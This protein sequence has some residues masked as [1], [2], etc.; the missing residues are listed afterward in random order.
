MRKSHS[1]QSRSNLLSIPHSPATSFFSRATRTMLIVKARWQLLGIISLYCLAACV[2]FL[3]TNYGFFLSYPQILF[4]ALSL[5]LVISYN[6]IFSLFY[7]KL[8]HL[9]WIDYLHIILDLL[10]ITGLIHFSGGSSSWFWPVYLIITIE[11]A[12]LLENGRCVM[13]I[14]FLGSLFYGALLIGEHTKLLTPV[15]MPASISTCDQSLPCVILMWSWVCFLNATVALVC[16]FFMKI[17]HKQAK[18]AGAREARLSSFL[19]HAH[20]L[21]FSFTP[22]GHIVYANKAWQDHLGYNPTTEHIHINQVMDNEQLLACQSKFTKI[23]H[24]EGIEPC[25]VTLLSSRGQTIA[26]E[27]SITCGQPILE[28]ETLL[29][30]MCRN[31]T[32]RKQSEE[33]LRFLAHHDTLTGLANRSCFMECAEQAKNMAKR[34]KGKLAFLFLDLDRFKTIN[35]TLGHGVGD[36]LLCAISQRLIGAVRESDM[37]SRLGGDEFAIMLT[38]IDSVSAIELLASKIIRAVAKPLTID[39]HELFITLSIGISLYP[40][41]STSIENLMKQADIAMYGAKNRGRNRYQLYQ[42]SMDHEANKRLIMEHGLRKALEHDELEIYYQPKVNIKSG[43]V[44]AL[45]A[46]LRWHHPQLGLVLPADIIPL[47]EETGLIIPIGEW[48]IRQVCRQSQLWRQQGQPPLRIAVNLSGQQIQQRDFVERTQAIMH[49]T[50]MQPEML[51]FEISEKLVMQNQEF[52][53]SMLNTLH[54]LGFQISIDNFGTGYSSLVHLMKHFAINTLKIDKSF[55]R[56]L[57]NNDKDAAI[58]SA[59]IDMG[60]RLNINIIA[61]GVETSGQLSF[62]KTQCCTEIQGYLYSEPLPAH[63]VP[64]M[65]WGAQEGYAWYSAVI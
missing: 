12:M 2:F 5:T 8:Q 49:E 64:E 46:L 29:W 52:A 54:N 38:N 20:D 11:A 57:E 19:E 62:L 21:I 50:V 55:I 35:D 63:A 41:D 30:A 44:T 26:V 15:L 13:A 53:V 45:E 22:T 4:L 14:G 6:L 39:K 37:V 43:K 28:G 48:V 36:Q 27:G 16:N 58:A 3:N 24:G 60:N 23:M 17:I 51:E 61:E 18:E 65:F 1:T 56:D 40:H 42:P 10:V 9:P 32:E 59:I 25:E 7:E 47:A 33:R 34:E 31:I